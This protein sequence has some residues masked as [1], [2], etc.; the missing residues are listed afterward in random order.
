MDFK[1][2]KSK[3]SVF[4]SAA[5]PVTAPDLPMKVEGDDD[6]GSGEPPIPLIIVEGFGGGAGNMLWGDFADHLNAGSQDGGE[7]EIRFV[8]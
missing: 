8:K 6:E 5:F 2:W 4:T 3:P 1:P 7:R